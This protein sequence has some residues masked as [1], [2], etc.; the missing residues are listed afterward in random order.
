MDFLKV[1]YENVKKTCIHFT[2]SISVSTGHRHI[3]VLFCTYFKGLF[4]L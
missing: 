2:T 4:C 3:E 1:I